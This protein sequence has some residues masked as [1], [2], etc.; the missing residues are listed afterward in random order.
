MPSGTS[1]DVSPSTAGYTLKYSLESGLYIPLT[2][3]S[4][5]SPYKVCNPSAKV[6]RWAPH[7]LQYWRPVGNRSALIRQS[8]Y[9]CRRPSYVDRRPSATVTD[10]PMTSLC[11]PLQFVIHR[12]YDRSYTSRWPQISVTVTFLGVNGRQWSLVVGDFFGHRW[13]ATGLTPSVTGPLCRCFFG[14]MLTRT[15]WYCLDSWYKNCNSNQRL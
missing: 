1:E 3:Q 7:G 5:T 14:G 4:L 15:C 9:D 11:R 2:R 8:S 6:M 13:S 10:R 12:Y